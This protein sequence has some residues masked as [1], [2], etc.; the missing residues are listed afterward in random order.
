MAARGGDLDGCD[1]SILRT[2][3]DQEEEFGRKLC[4]FDIGKVCVCCG[5]ME[6]YIY[7]S[8]TQHGPA[9]A[10]HSGNINMVIVS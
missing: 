4:V 7:V 1:L 5:F 10:R 2:L 3:E 9:A 8:H 6:V